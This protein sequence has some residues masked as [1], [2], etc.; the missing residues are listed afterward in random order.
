MEKKIIVI[1]RYIYQYQKY[2][3]RKKLLMARFFDLIYAFVK[4]DK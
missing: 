1:Q 2:L 3:M 4:H